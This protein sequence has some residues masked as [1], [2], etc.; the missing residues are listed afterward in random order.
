MSYEEINWR[1]LA[2]IRTFALERRSEG[3]WASYAE[4]VYSL[5]SRYHTLDEIYDATHP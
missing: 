1:D 3:V 4:S 5:A 2:S